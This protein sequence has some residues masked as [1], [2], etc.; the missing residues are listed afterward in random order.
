MH[1]HMQWLHPAATHSVVNS[2]FQPQVRQTHSTKYTLCNGPQQVHVTFQHVYH[3]QL[4]ESE[5]C[6]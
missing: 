5:L 6:M 2:H 3:Q 1:H 4:I